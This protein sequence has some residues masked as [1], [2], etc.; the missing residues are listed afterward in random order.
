MLINDY[1]DR[2]RVFDTCLSNAMQK[3]CMGAVML[4]IS[5]E[6]F[7]ILYNSTVFES[8]SGVTTMRNK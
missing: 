4:A 2:R 7:K 6:T 5:T 1:R 8:Q 3:L